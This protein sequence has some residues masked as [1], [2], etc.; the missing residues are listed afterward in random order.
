MQLL[1]ELDYW[2]KKGRIKEL[3]M[4]DK[5]LDVFFNNL[6]RAFFMDKTNKAMAH[7]DSAFPIGHGQTISQP[8]LVLMMTKFL[9]L[10]KHHRVLEIGTGSG[11]QTAFLAEFAK[12]VY[13]IERIEDLALKAK[14]RLEELGYLNVEYKVGDG[15]LGWPEF[16]PFDRV[17]ITAGTGKKPQELINQMA[18]NGKMIVPLGPREMQSLLL[19]EKDELG[20]V[21]QTTLGYVRFVEMK[22]TYGWEE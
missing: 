1:L 11:Y 20:K 3:L 13:T 18:L 15:S 12:Q 17:M 4:K 6:D 7:V 9:D 16:A 10:E 19:I 5:Q 14:E 21:S 2:K 22:G 8:S